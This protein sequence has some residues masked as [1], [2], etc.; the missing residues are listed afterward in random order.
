MSPVFLVVGDTARNPARSGIQTVV[1]SLAAAFAGL[2]AKVRLVL[3]NSRLRT[4]RPLAPELSIGPAAEPL[5]DP[6]DRLPPALWSQPLAWP[7]WLLAGARGKFVPVHRHPLHRRAPAGTW[8]VMPELMYKERA[9]QLV[10]YVHRRGWRLAVILY[11]TIPIEH[12]EYVPPTLPTQHTGYLRAFSKADLVLPI[13]EASAKGWRKFLAAEALEGPPVQVCPLA[14]DLV[15]VPRVRQVPDRSSC[16]DSGPIRM[17]CVSTLEPRKNHDVLLAAY[18]RAVTARPDLR[19]ELDLVGAAY[20]GSQDIEK[21]VSEASARLPGLHWHGQIEYEQLEA[22][23]AA[24]DFTIYPSVVEG[25]GLPVIESL[26][27]GRPCVCANFGVM[28]ENAADGGCLVTD[29]RDPDALA[30][31]ILTLAADPALRRK[32]TDEATSRP[33]KTWSEYAQEILACLAAH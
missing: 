2:E 32:L 3:W 31:A 10:D 13:S 24:C 8:V 6:P 15:G 11:D 12:P 9:A 17:L 33:L 20:A 4:L 14:C 18:E 19:L 21:S 28:A 29:V 26:W 30:E 23:Y 22:L 16:A 5:R 7:S 1:R 25:F 27:F